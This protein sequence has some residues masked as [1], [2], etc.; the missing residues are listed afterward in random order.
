MTY[1]HPVDDVRNSPDL[2]IEQGIDCLRRN[3]ISI[4]LTKGP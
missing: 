3:E 2:F 1:H 4:I